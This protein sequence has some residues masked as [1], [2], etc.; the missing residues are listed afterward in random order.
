MLFTDRVD[1]G[2]RLAEALRH[3][4]GENPVVLGLP[5]GGVPV[6][7]QVARALHA[8]LDVIVVR[9]L[10]VP[11]QRE[12]GF[13]A[14]GEGGVRVI[15]D[16][17]VR[18]GR[19][20]QDDLDSVEQAEAAELTRQ[21]HRFR[22][23]RTRLPLTGR[24]AIVVDDGIATGATAAAACQVVRAQGAARVVLAAP[25]APPEAAERL[26]AQADEL[27]CLSTPFGFSAVGEWYRDFSQTPDDE[28]ISL[29][30][31]AASGTDTGSDAPTGP[32]TPDAPDTPHTDTDT[33]TGTGTGAG[34]EADGDVTEEVAIDAAG[35]RLTGDLDLPSGA[36]AVVM[37]AHGSGSSR[38]S[39]RNRRVAAALN[40]AGLGTL[41][42]DLLTP[43]E[44]ADRANVFDI[45]T[46]A[47]RLTDATEWLRGRVSV[48]IGYFG[49]STGAAAALRAAA[50]PN[51]DIG[52]VVSR[53]GRPDL[54]GPLLVGVRAPT[55]LIVGGNDPLVL[56]LNRE[57]KEA[58]RCETQLEIVPGATHLFEEHGALDQVA[59]LARDWFLGHLVG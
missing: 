57:A 42:F 46:L 28:V 22:A 36:K 14:I 5:R 53:G 30:E 26:R 2:Q 24:T 7:F 27:V 52:A 43:A 48:P 13:G 44:E 41:L 31:Q 56:D 20:G 17:I 33:D 37:F 59:D 34:T 8:P 47:G 11:Y 38:H 45:E 51:A 39:P 6:A 9:K 12:L 54:A 35:V 49:A 23:G 4:E 18:R 19:L 25:V 3:L 1:A 29:L 21:A 40:R 50:A 55:L 16:D 10:G 15:S 32:H 58:L